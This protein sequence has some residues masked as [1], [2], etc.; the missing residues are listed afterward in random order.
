MSA[1]LLPL[2]L[3]AALIAA[4][5]LASDSEI[6]VDLQGTWAIDGQCDD[7]DKTVTF[8]ASTLSMAGEDEQP[9][10]YYAKDSPEGFGAIHWAEEGVVSNFAYDPENEVLLF[11]E[12]GYGM[13]IAPVEYNW[14]AD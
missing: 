14:C 9:A 7:L 12:Q 1:K 10:V 2:A 3:A 6:P 4:P 13:G 5:A 11:N 8:T